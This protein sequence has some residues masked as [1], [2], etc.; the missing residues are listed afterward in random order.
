MT[1]NDYTHWWLAPLQ[2]V[3]IT[4][5]DVQVPK[6]ARDIRGVKDRQG[7]ATWNEYN[8]MSINVKTISIWWIY[9]KLYFCIITL[10]IMF[11]IHN[12]SEMHNS[13][14]P[15][16]H[17]KKHHRVVD[18][19][20][21]ES[22]VSCLDCD[23]DLWHGGVD[24]HRGAPSRVGSGRSLGSGS[25]LESFGKWSIKWQLCMLRSYCICIVILYL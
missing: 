5:T 17:S 6:I 21:S 22:Q 7:F 15:N 18:H 4:M 23:S 20:G 12:L 25:S 19:R 8:E 14:D 3:F 9:I 24:P 10:F 1:S 16:R 2:D 13:T 11:R